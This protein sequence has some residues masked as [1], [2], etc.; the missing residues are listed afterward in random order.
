[1]IGKLL[2]FPVACCIM[3]HVIVAAQLAIFWSPVLLLCSGGRGR[4]RCSGE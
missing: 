1:M 3:F 2:L 4:D